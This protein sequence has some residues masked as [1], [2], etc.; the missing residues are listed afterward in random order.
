[1][2]TQPVSISVPAP[3]ASTVT[4]VLQAILA[5][6]Q[7]AAAALP[8]IF[9]YQSIFGGSHTTISGPIIAQAHQ[10]HPV[11]GQIVE[12]VL[13]PPAAPVVPDVPAV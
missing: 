7:I 9:Q 13:T 12:A 10:L 1:M 2:S 5:G 4:N 3:H 8:V 11:S 6:L